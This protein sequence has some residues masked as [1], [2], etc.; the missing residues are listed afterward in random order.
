MSCLNPRFINVKQCTCGVDH[1]RCL[2]VPCGKCMN[3]LRRKA[4]VAVVQNYLQMERSSSA[5]FFTLTYEDDKVPLTFSQHVYDISTGEC[6]YKETENISV[7]DAPNYKY[8]WTDKARCTT[9]NSFSEVNSDGN[10]LVTDLSMTLRRKDVSRWIHAFRSAYKRDT[11]E[12]SPL[13]YYAVGEYGPRTGRPHY[14]VL[15][16]NITRK[17]AHMLEERWASRLGFVKVKECDLT[18]PQ[19]RTALG[20]YLGKYLSKGSFENPAVEQGLVEKP[21]KCASRLFGRPD[22]FVAKYYKWFRANDLFGRYDFNRL[23]EATQ[24]LI[25]NVILSRFHFSIDGYHYPLP[26]TLKSRITKQLCFDG[27]MRSRPVFASIANDA[28]ERVFSDTQREFLKYSKA[29][30]DLCGDALSDA[31]SSWKISNVHS[32]EAHSKEDLQ[33]FYAKSVL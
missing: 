18:K 30:P 29:H 6:L 2:P 25:K 10:L 31:Y 16:Y 33:R 27:K 17:D 7:A 32:L 23:S 21:R 11:G 1:Y 19:T 15:V 20:R 22:E 24:K 12:T 8:L 4:N 3:C 14:H 13:K 9:V 28:F 5:W 26:D